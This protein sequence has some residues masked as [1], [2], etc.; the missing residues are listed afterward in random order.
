MTSAE[1]RRD[2]QLARLYD[3][4]DAVDDAID[5]LWTTVGGLDPGAHRWP[6]RVADEFER[7]HTKR[8]QLEAQVVAFRDAPLSKDERMTAWILYRR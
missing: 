3:L 4:I 7:L 6:P 5:A 8:E 1:N 2:D